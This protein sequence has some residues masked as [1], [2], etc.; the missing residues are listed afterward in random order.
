MKNQE[1]STS[2]DLLFEQVRFLSCPLSFHDFEISISH[3][4]SLLEGRYDLNLDYGEKIFV[5]KT[6]NK[7]PYY[8]VAFR[9]LYKETDYRLDETSIPSK[10]SKPLTTEEILE[11]QRLVIAGQ[12]EKIEEKYGSSDWKVF[13]G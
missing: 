12:T 4:K 1:Q 6:Q 13:E 7:N 8:I 10:L 3:D 5:I 9:L 11:M 2:F